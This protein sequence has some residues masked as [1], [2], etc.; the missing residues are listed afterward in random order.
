MKTLIAVLLLLTSS[1]T[2]ILKADIDS[3]LVASYNFSG[4]Y[5]DASG[6]GHNGTPISNPTFVNDRFNNSSSALSLNGDS[7]YVSLPST[8]KLYTDLTISFWFKTTASDPDPFYFGMFL[9]DRDICNWYRDWDITLGSG[10]K[11]IFTTG[12]DNGDH[13]LATAI[14]L[15]DGYWHHIT[16]VLDSALGRKQIFVDRLLARTSNFSVTSFV[17]NNIPIFVG[18]SVCGPMDHD[19][20]RGEIDD[21]RFYDRAITQGEINKLYFGDSSYVRII[22]EGLYDSLNNVLTRSDT[23]DIYFHK[24]YDIID[25][26]RAVIDPVT[27]MA[28]FSVSDKSGEV[29]FLEVRNKNCFHAISDLF[30]VDYS[31]IVY[32][33]TNRDWMSGQVL[34]K[35]D[36][37]PVRYGMYSGDVNQDNT[38]DASDAAIVDND[39]ANL[40]TGYSITDLNGDMIV[41]ATDFA[42]ID[43]NANRFISIPIYNSP[44]FI[45]GGLNW[46]R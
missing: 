18:A 33:F 20:Y 21:I 37:S 15:N 5:I 13:Q 42:I 23:V 32:D 28:P 12:T 29:I 25:S 44:F 31:Q 16:I 17:N 34:K 30:Y 22:P 38:I 1:F 6:H 3:G 39:A 27:F 7:Q 36:T 14:D 45:F 19:R 9:I 8:I 41:D 4:N 10:G 24:Y 43:E 2:G 46:K 11:I 26:A 40:V 35:I